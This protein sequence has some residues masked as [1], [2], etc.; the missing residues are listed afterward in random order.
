M[1]APFQITIMNRQDIPDLY[2]LVHDERHGTENAYFDLAAAEQG[3]HKRLVFLIRH[4]E[5]GQLAG[6]VHY[7]R[8]PKYKPF[9]RLGIPEIQDLYIRADSRRQGLGARLIAHCEVQALTDERDEIGI[10]VG[11]TPDFGSAQRLYVRLGYMPDGAGVVCDREPIQIGQVQVLDD[12]LC[13]ML[14][15]SLRRA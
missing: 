3:E 14:L 9:N 7:N 8:F 5:T 4:S 6:Y 2:S 10:G 1:S 13:L 11:I 15:K 12:R